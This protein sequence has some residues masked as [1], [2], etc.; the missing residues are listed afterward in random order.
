MYCLL[1]LPANAL[2]P[3]DCLSDRFVFMIQE[4]IYN[5]RMHGNIMVSENN[6]T[7]PMHGL[8]VKVRV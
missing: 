8:S 1:H 6:T 3:S 7:E 2:E 4:D 5:L